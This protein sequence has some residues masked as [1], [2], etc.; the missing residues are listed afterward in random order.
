MCTVFSYICGWS[1]EWHC[2]SVCRFTSLVQI[3]GIEFFLLRHL[4]IDICHYESNLWRTVGWTEIF[5]LGVDFLKLFC[6][7]RRLY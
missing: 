3:E 2:Q 7:H 4:E 1:V 5:H 6:W